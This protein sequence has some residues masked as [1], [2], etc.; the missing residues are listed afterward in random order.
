MFFSYF[1]RRRN[2]SHPFDYVGSGVCRLF[3]IGSTAFCGL[4]AALRDRKAD[5]FPTWLTYDSAKLD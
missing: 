1:S 5:A 3:G 2:D 4:P